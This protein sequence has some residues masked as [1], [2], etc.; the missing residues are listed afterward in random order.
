MKRIFVCGLAAVALMASCTSKQAADSTD[1]AA[2]AE[3]TAATV[4]LAGRWTI[5]SIAVNDTTVVKPGEEAPG[6]SQFAIF[7]NDSY[8]FKT[9]CNSIS[10]GYTLNGDSISF[11]EGI[12]TMMACE[13]MAT[14]DALRQV[15]PAVVTISTVNDSTIQLNTADAGRY[16]VLTCCAETEK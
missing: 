6:E 5:D 13:N 16:I 11:G 7:E 15:L 4:D 3:A 2:E 9:N 12:A 10:G 8:A 1:A 14:E